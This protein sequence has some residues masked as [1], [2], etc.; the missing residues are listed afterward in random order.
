VKQ[1]FL[2]SGKA[3]G[4]KDSTANFLKQKLP[5]K[6]LIIHNADYLK[7]IAKEYMGWNG[8]KDDQGRQLLQ[9]LGTDKIRLGLKK[10]LFWV[11]KT[12]EVIEILEDTYDYFIVSDVRF[13]NEVFLP[14][15]RFP[16]CVTTIRVERLNFFNG[17]SDEQQ[18]H[19]SEVDLDNF[20]FDYRIVSDNGL[21]NLEVEVDKLIEKLKV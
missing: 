7:Y 21:D 15:A 16:R 11:D 2:I 13:V 18:K 6:S 3:Q 4:G 5:G 1:I 9:W 17:L 19:L 20:T 8:L 14:Q 10:P 12:C